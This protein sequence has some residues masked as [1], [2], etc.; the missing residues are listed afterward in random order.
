MGVGDVI[1]LWDSLNRNISIYINP[2]GKFYLK[3]ILLFRII[4]LKVLVLD[5]GEGLKCETSQVGC[6]LVCLNRYRVGVLS[7]MAKNAGNSSVFDL[8][9]PKL[10]LPDA[11]QPQQTLGF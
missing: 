11:N 4:V 1:K 8:F 6:N 2:V 3:Y 7:R 5:I 9:Q 10:P